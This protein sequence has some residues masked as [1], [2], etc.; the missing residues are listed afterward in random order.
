MKAYNLQA[1]IHKLP[2]GNLEAIGLGERGRGRQYLLIPCPTGIQNGD[3]VDL[4]MTATGKPKIVR[5][6]FSGEW[7]VRVSTQYTY[8][9]GTSGRILNPNREQKIK[10]ISCGLGAYGDAGR[11]GSWKDY[12]LQAPVGSYLCVLPSG[13]RSKI[14]SYYLYFGDS[15]VLKMN[16]E[17]FGVFADLE[18]LKVDEDSTTWEEL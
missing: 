4:S 8:T 16:K 13:G 7:L 9:R 15:N 3:P 11:I 5:G 12:L 17:E 10:V 6:N 14:P 18:N 1:S 2:F